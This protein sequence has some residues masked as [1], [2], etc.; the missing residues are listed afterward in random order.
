MS[1][2]RVVAGALGALSV[3]NGAA[4]L[5]NGAVWHEAAR[6]A[7]HIGPYHAHA[8]AD[9]GAA[10]L[11]AGLGLLVRAWQPRLWPLAIA[12]IGFMVLHG[13]VHMS[14]A[15]GGHAHDTAA[16]IGLLAIP[17]AL[18]LWAAS[19]AKGEARAS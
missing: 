14:G 18:A 17:A 2:K 19:P 9:A 8:V 10:F 16:S 15:T 13:V 4:M 7:V 11:A 12:G 5:A 3:L 6:W 1:A